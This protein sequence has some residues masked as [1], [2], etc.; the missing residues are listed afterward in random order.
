LLGSQRSLTPWRFA[1]ASNPLTPSTMM[2]R[3][4]SMLAPTSAIR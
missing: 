1:V 3:A 2:L 4:S